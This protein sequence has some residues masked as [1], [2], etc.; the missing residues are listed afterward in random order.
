MQEVMDALGKEH[1]DA[2]KI[3]F[4]LTHDRYS[5]GMTRIESLLHEKNT[6]SILEKAKIFDLQGPTE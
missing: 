1:T 2:A 6:V 4:F 5:N 3:R